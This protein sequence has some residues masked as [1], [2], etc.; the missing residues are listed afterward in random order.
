MDFEILL[1]MSFGLHRP[2]WITFELTTDLFKPNHQ[3][4]AATLTL[5]ALNQ[6]ETPKA[7]NKCWSIFENFQH[8]KNHI[9]ANLSG[10]VYI[11]IYVCIYVY[12]FIQIYISIYYKNCNTFIRFS[13]LPTEPAKAAPAAS[14]MTPKSAVQSKK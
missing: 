9:F 6:L 11:Y 8:F 4:D 7:T 3:P 5:N 14:S 2:L 1:H 12:I 10:L 13:A